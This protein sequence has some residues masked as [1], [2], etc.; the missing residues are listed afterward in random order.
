MGQEQ[1]GLRSAIPADIMPYHIFAVYFLRSCNVLA[2]CLRDS[3]EQ[4]P[5]IPLH[6][7]PIQYQKYGIPAINSRNQ[8]RF[9]QE[10]HNSQII[11]Y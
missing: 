1:N 8:H 10:F 6:L 2:D 4:F 11:L 9:L 3:S 7:R 5:K